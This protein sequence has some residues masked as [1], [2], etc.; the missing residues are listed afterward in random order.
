MQSA[1]KTVRVFGAL[2]D[3]PKGV[4]VLGFVSMLMDISSEIIHSL[5]PVYLVTVMGTS[6][7][8]VGLIEGVSEA[9]VALIKVVSG[10]V[11]DK[12][13]K[14]RQLVALGYGLAALS[15]PA[16]PLAQS[17]GWLIAAR[18]TDRVGKGIRGAPRDALI[19]DLSPVAVRGAS[20]GLRQSLDTLGYGKQF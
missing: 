8:V 3:V 11:S 2:G 19:A 9:S 17:L 20:F 5:L 10:A 12:T 13:G 4:W 15:K 1:P 6:T 14:R 18:I 16:F 7:V